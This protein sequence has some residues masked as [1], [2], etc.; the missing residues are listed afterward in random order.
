MIG[1]ALG[2]LLGNKD[3]TDDDIDY[4]KIDIENLE[5]ILAHARVVQNG[6]DSYFLDGYDNKEELKL[7]DDQTYKILGRLNKH[8]ELKKDELTHLIK[9]I[10]H[11]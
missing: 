11:K 2:L 1:I 5:N 8:G 6:K 7:L 10:I 9:K 3:T 4:K